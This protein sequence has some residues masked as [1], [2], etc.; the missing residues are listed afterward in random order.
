MKQITKIE[1]HDESSR[2]TL[3]WYKPFKVYESENK[4]IELDQENGSEIR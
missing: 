4:R 1:C 3:F 2:N